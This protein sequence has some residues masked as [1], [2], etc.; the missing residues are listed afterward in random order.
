MWEARVKRAGQ[1]ATEYPAVAALLTFYSKVLAAQQEI[2]DRLRH[3]KGW[4]PSGIL[5]QDLPVLRTM[6]S[7]LLAVVEANG[8]ENL[9]IEA[10]TLLE[11]QEAQIDEMLLGYWRS[12]GDRQFFAKAFLQPYMQ[13]VVDT[14]AR[15]IGRRIAG[16]TTSCPRCCGKPQLSF[17][18]PVETAQEIGRRNL[19]CSTCLGH[20][21][22]RRVVCAH[23]GEER[24]EKLYYFSAP[25]YEHI[26]IEACESCKHYLKGIDHSLLGLAVLLVDEVAAAPLD[27]WAREQGYT[28]IELNLVGL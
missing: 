1:L 11:A 26:R 4:L 24:P 25:D 3:H 17:L 14:G 12:P 13:W 22:F 18:G 6:T 5:E 15:P 16:G 19:L 23:C 27:L 28:K 10:R 9:S 21:P 7:G 8:S 2:Y 20:W